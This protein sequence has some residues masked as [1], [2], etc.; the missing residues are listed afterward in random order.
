MG[1]FKNLFKPRYRWALFI[2]HGDTEIRYAMYCNSV[3]RMIGYVMGYYEHGS[4]PVQPWSLWLF[5]FPSQKR[6][7]LQP[8]FFTPDGANI[9]P[10]LIEAIE[11]IDQRW[12]IKG[13]EP[14]FEEYASKN[15]LPL[16]AHGAGKSID[17][18]AL[19]ASLNDPQEETFYSV[20]D[21][22]FGVR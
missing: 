11:S 1:F 9:T 5:S 21:G 10:D 15:K 22:V 16:S 8:E 12:K 17:V 19:Y 6:L 3:I 2:V 7:L 13:D 18:T 4:K 14:V 20:M